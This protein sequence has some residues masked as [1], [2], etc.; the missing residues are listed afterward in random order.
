[1][2]FSIRPGK[3]DRSRI[4][5]SDEAALR[6]WIKRLDA[7]K[8]KIAMAIAKVGDT[9]SAVRKDLAAAQQLSAKAKA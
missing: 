9:A 1:M 8:E 3:P 4:D 6:H 5:L 7:S 2:N